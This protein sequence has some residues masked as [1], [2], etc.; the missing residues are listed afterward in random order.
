MPPLWAPDGKEILFYGTH[1]GTQSKPAR[2]WIV[3]LA[4]GKPRLA[5]LP[6]VEQN[7]DPAF[8][9]H[10]WIR[11]ADDREWIVYSTA[12]SRSWKLWQIEIPPQDESH[13]EPELLASGSGDLTAGTASADGK[14]AYRIRVRDY[15]IYQ[16]PTSLGGQ[17]LDPTSQLSLPLGGNH[18]SPTVSHDGKW[19]AYN[20][21]ISGKPDTILLRDLSTGTD[22]LLDDKGRAPGTDYAASIS[23]D[24]SMVIFERDC[25]EGTW[26]DDPNSPLPCG[27]MVAATGG[28]PKQICQ[29]CTPRGFSSDGSVVLLQKYDLTNVDKDRIV[30]LDLRTGTEHGFLSLPDNPVFHAYFSW[31]DRWVVFKKMRP[32]ISFPSQILIAPVRHGSAAA[33]AEWIAVTD[34]QHID[35][36]PQFSADGNTVYFTSTRDGYLCVWAQRLDPV[37]KHPLG[38]PFAYEHF[39]N[40]TG[41]TAAFNQGR[42]DLSVASD[43]ILINLPQVTHSEIWMT[44]LR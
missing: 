1:T 16:I 44:Q 36:K 42:S 32:G 37:T 33:E 4:P 10:D 43:K 13:Q 2:W 25:K 27:F 21:S 12:Q 23:P 24:G 7:H 41:R 6:G 17:K 3:P 11:T 39:H 31:D 26:P 29:Y 20:S 5:H 38:S 8:A 18:V 15:A 40:A 34:G 19:M 28:Q 14:L 35:D 22:H 30:A 9:V